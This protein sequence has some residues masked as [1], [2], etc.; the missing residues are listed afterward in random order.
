MKKRDEISEAQPGLHRSLGLV[1]LTFYGVGTIV[2]GGFYALIGKVAGHAGSLT[3]L[4]FLTASVVALFSAFSFAELSARYPYSAGEAHYVREAF[5]RRRL[6]QLVG[7]LVV[8]TGVVSAATLA[9]AFAGFTT[10]LAPWPEYWVVIAVT[11]AMALVAAW[12]IGESAVLVAGITVVEVAG[13]L[14]VAG[15]GSQAALE[16]ANR[17]PE[18]VPSFSLHEWSGVMAGAYLGFYSF[19]GFEDLVNVAEEVK[20]P[21]RTLP[22]AIF[23]SL[24]LTVTLY[25]L[26]AVVAVLAVPASELAASQAPLSIVAERYLGSGV[27][28]TYIGM[29]AGV[30][31]ALVQIVMSSRVLYGMAGAGAAPSIFAQVHPRTRTPLL[32]TAAAAVCVLV[33]ALWLPI[34]TLAKATSTIL[35]L[36][37]A[38]VNFSLWTLKVTRRLEP[39]EG[40]SF[41]A[42]LPLTGGALCLGFVA[43]QVSLYLSTG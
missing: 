29:L 39:H 36:V 42:W 31:G 16:G 17:W 23:I 1:T 2:G 13:L 25:V 43:V 38:L 30:N 32:A 7:G 4:A 21:S 11:L 12:G 24:A 9:R 15:A 20:R 5:G 3:P 37:Y 26:V 28:L 40:P 14:L 41:P 27:L 19:V 18:L 33:L 10:T 8:V 6:S 34:E 22:A 35:L